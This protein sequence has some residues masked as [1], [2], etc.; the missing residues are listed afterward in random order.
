M[1]KALFMVIVTSGRLKDMDRGRIEVRYNSN[2]FLKSFSISFREVDNRNR[3]K[4]G[5][6]EVRYN[7]K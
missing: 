1:V 6:T 2:V 4:E 7:S 5:S 3:V